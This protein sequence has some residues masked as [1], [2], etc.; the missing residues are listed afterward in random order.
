MSPNTDYLFANLDNKNNF[1][2]SMKKM[3]MVNSMWFI[4]RNDT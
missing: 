4:P 3:E 1:E 2:A